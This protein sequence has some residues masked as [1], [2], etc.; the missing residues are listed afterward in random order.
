MNNE[1]IKVIKT[2]DGEKEFHFKFKSKKCI[3]LEKATGKQFLE[4]LQDVSMHNIARLLKAACVLPEN[5]DE[6][7][8][9][10]TL[11]VDSSLER[12]MLDV[13]YEAATIS[14]IISRTDKDKIDNAMNDEDLKKELL[15]NNK[16]K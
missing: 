16:K 10:D 6:Y 9:L 5:V 7:E 2:N 14:G 11:L 15:E 8:L 4:L 3:D 12:V 1:L 13:V